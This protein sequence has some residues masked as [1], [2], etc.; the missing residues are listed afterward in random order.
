MGV[1]EN[2]GATI[3]ISMIKLSI[4]SVLTAKGKKKI[5]QLFCLKPEGAAGSSLL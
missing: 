4:S 5:V 1:E 2:S 3:C